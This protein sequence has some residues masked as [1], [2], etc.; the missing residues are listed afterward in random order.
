MKLETWFG[1]KDH[2][3]FNHSTEYREFYLMVFFFVC[4]L[5][6][7]TKRNATQRKQN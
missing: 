7:N 6:G 5:K 3:Y 4:R 1:F 2:L